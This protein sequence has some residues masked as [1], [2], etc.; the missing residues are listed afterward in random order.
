MTN[1]KK[2]A[3]EIEKGRGGDKHIGVETALE[4]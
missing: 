3:S 1:K 2:K 4:F